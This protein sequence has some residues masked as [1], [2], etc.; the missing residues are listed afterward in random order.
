[1][2]GN[3][4]ID[5]GWR[6]STDWQRLSD[7]VARLKAKIEE[8]YHMSDEDAAAEWHE[9][10]IAAEWRLRQAERRRNRG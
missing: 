5:S 3:D 4:P 8:A 7:V 1:M 10:L 6:E 9:D 2:A